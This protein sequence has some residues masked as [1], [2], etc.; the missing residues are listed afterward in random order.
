MVLDKEDNIGEFILRKYLKFNEKEN[1][2]KTVNIYKF[3]KHFSKYTYVPFL[4][5][6]QKTMEFNKYYESVIKMIA[7]LE[8]KEIKAK[9]PDGDLWYNR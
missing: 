4:E 7:M 2:Y 8:T 9:C 5:A 6:Y 3:N 1:Y